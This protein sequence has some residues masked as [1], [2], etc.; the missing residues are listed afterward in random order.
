MTP[1]DR[2]VARPRQLSGGLGGTEYLGGLV[3]GD[4][5]YPDRLLPGAEA[6][7]EDDRTGWNSEFRGEEPDELRVGRSLDRRGRQSDLDRIAVQPHD[8]SP[9]GS[10]LNVNPETDPIG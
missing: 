4:P 7:L 6:P 1:R 3:G 2:L 9:R 8:F 10:G 5:G